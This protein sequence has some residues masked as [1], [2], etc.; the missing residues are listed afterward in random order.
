MLVTRIDIIV[1][2]LTGAFLAM[3]IAFI[4]YLWHTIPLL[5]IIR[6]HLERLGYWAIHKPL[7]SCLICMA[8]WYGTAI[9]LL[10]TGLQYSM[11]HY[12]LITIGNCMVSLL[13]ATV[14]EYVEENKDEI[15]F[16]S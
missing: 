14:I 8:F 10:I 3:V 9:S 2:L 15:D 5:C 4:Y 12:I 13:L 16:R 7:C 1:D 11:V 6:H